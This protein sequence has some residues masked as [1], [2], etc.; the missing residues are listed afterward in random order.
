MDTILFSLV[1][2][3]AAPP[4]QEPNEHLKPLA[5]LEGSWVGTGKYGEVE[6]EDR[7]TYTLTHGGH[8]LQ[9]KA[10][11]RMGG[12]VV[13]S[14]SGMIGYDK[15]KNKLVMHTFFTSGEIG[16]TESLPSKEKNVWRFAVRIG[17]KQPWEDARAI[18]TKVDRD[19]YTY[20]V[21]M[22]RGDEF[23]T[24]F[25]ATYKRKKE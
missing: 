2:F 16:M 24:F 20:V 22:K 9:L 1:L 6:M 17:V 11:A 18:M 14:G 13:Q 10:V 3:F 8:F 25:D 5:W 19:T 15:A 7:I 4:Q 12:Q 21:Q 23:V